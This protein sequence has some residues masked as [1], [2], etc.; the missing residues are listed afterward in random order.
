MARQ[1]SIHIGGHRFVRSICTGLSD[2]LEPGRALKVINSNAITH[3]LLC[4]FEII[5][6]DCGKVGLTWVVEASETCVWLR[7][8]SDSTRTCVYGSLSPRFLHFF[9]NLVERFEFL[10]FL[11]LYLFSFF[12]YIFL[13]FFF[14]L[15]QYNFFVFLF[16]F[17]L[18]L[19]PACSF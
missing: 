3:S 16:F 9:S 13:P 6:V 7:L 2:V 12:L 1:S 18:L 19:F 11:V 4:W 8:S 17:V 5:D 15:R 14:I 10:L